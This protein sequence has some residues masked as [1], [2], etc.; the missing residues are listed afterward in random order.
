MRKFLQLGLLGLLMASQTYAAEIANLRNGFSIRHERHEVVGD[1]TRL[2]MSAEPSSGYVDVPSAQIENF[3]P[4]PPEPQAITSRGQTPVDLS[5]IVSEASTR[6]QVDADF[7]ASVIRAESGNNPRA[8]S[9]KGAQGLM[10]LM[11]GT[12]SQLG[13][14]NSF[15]P[16]ENVD[17]GVRYLRELLLL[18]N[19]DMIKALA[20]YNAGPQRVQQYKGVPPYH[21]THAYVARVINDYNRKKL[22]QRKRQR[23]PEVQAGAAVK[24]EIAQSAAGPA[25]GT[26]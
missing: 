3:E 10:Q 5:T 17:G 18:Y 24:P 1:T 9:R 21:E 2:Y 6:S 7:I 26:E 15:D 11:P 14:K 23:R 20:A 19:N 4:A 25:G 12:A 16:A 8:I 22:A 13:V